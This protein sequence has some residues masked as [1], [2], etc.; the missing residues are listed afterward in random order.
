MRK[1]DEGRSMSLLVSGRLRAL[2]PIE[3]EAPRVLG[4]IISGETVGEMS[5]FS[6]EPRSADILAVR[7]SYVVEFSKESFEKITEKYPSVLMR[8]SE[9]VIKRLRS[10]QEAN[11]E[12][13]RLSVVTL[14]G[15]RTE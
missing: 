6:G 11:A 1:G 8:V 4:D 3:N 7:D 5:L 14:V 2:L 13:G 12:A 10:A 9:I 15:K